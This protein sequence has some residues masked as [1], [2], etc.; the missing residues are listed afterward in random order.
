MRIPLS[1]LAWPEQAAIVLVMTPCAAGNSCV[2]IGEGS[3]NEF[4]AHMQEIGIA[5]LFLLFVLIYLKGID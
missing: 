1:L 2:L 5:F 3:S 4:L